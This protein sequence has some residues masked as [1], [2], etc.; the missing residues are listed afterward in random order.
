MIGAS[1]QSTP[2]PP[3][4]GLKSMAEVLITHYGPIAFGVIS[5]IVIWY[6][7]VKPILD[8]NKI[9]FGTVQETARTIRETSIIMKETVG[10]LNNVIGRLENLEMRYE[11]R[12]DE[13]RN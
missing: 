7:I 2:I 13:A 9:D 11:R 6:A 10:A 4:A 1:L 12:S 3:S 5:L 8:Q